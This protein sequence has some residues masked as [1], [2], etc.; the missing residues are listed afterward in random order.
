MAESLWG[1]MWLENCLSE[2]RFWESQRINLNGHGHMGLSIFASDHHH[3]PNCIPTYVH[4]HWPHHLLCHWSTQGPHLQG[5]SHLLTV[6]SI[7]G[8][9]SSCP[10]GPC[11]QWQRLGSN[12]KRVIG[13][14]WLQLMCCAVVSF[15]KENNQK[16]YLSTTVQLLEWYAT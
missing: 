6:Q 8:V 14:T 11:S 2:S 9:I 15:W 3:Q 1:Q 4:I 5:H 16:K 7:S 13:R 12:Q 10:G